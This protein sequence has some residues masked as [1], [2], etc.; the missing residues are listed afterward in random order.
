MLER[1]LLLAKRKR[2]G[3]FDMG[4]KM[5]WVKWLKENASIFKK[6]GL[7]GEQF[8]ILSQIY[9]A[10]IGGGAQMCYSAMS[11]PDGCIIKIDY[12]LMDDLVEKELLVRKCSPYGAK[13]VTL[14]ENGEVMVS[15][16]LSEEKF[17]SL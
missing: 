15:K 12:A 6:Y 4:L 10:K 11:L 2:K 14:T 8:Y 16:I 13:Y 1:R 5:D 9:K 3:D 17:V 7:T